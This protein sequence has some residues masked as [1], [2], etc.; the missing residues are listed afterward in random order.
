MQDGKALQAGTSHMLG[1]NFSRQFGLTFQ[2]EAGREEY[3]WNTSWG[4]S[5]RLVGGTG[6]DARRR[7]R[8][9]GPAE[10]GADVQVIVTPIART[11][12]Q[13]AVVMEKADSNRGRRSR[14]G[15]VRAA[16]DRRRHLSPGSE[17]LRVGA[18]GRAAARGD[19]PAGCGAGRGRGGA[20][21]RPRSR[22][23]RKEALPEARAV[24]GIGEPAGRLADAAPGSRAGPPGGA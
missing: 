24:D 12:E 10:A 11:D 8:R 17:V 7:C 18:K 15:G 1:Q 16:A 22:G 23:D 2:S 6:D 19:R 20:A 9:R 14:T 5:T 13:A 3:A 4:V 21:R